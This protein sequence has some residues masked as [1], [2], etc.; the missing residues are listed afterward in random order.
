M[1]RLWVLSLILLVACL[2]ARSPIRRAEPTGEVQPPVFE[3]VPGQTFIERFDPPGAGSSLSLVISA[4]VSNPNSFGVTLES[5]EYS[6]RLAGNRIVQG[7]LEPQT[8]IGAGRSSPLSF[9]V[10]ADL[11]GRAPLIKAVAGA[12]TDTPLVFE[13][14]GST[15]FASLSTAF[16]TRRDV[17]LVGALSA[18]DTVTPP[19]LQLIELES[20]VF[21][22]RAGVP[23]VQLKIRA[24]NRGEVGYFVYGR[25]LEV[26]LNGA[27]IALQDA[28]PTPLPAGQMGEL[29]LLFYPNSERL[30]DEGRTA[31]SA[32][33]AGVTTGVELRG[34]LLLDVLGVDTFEVGGGWNLAGFVSGE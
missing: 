20:Q 9:R 14:R 22:L 19:D 27:L 5:V 6:L 23:V 32:A 28:L 16:E 15:R 26:L 33:L 29:E 24:E 31:L 25:D 3:L 10:N 8:F 2:P 12:Y 13:L 11:E 21:E 34:D 30:N 17:L 1:R 18:R 7:E 4:Q